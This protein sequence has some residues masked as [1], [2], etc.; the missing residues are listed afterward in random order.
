V[1]P[2]PLTYAN[3]TA[4]VPMQSIELRDRSGTIV[5]I[6]F[7]DNKLRYLA[8][9][10]FPGDI[11]NQVDGLYVIPFTISAE[12][13]VNGGV[14]GYYNF[15]GDEI[16]RIYTPSTLTAGSYQIVI[17]SYELCTLELKNGVSNIV[18]L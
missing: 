9:Q 4:F 6:N 5:G 3:V 18:K 17:M 13:S 7:S 12:N 16:L 2:T 10:V 11:F 8:S 1:L 14:S 15:T